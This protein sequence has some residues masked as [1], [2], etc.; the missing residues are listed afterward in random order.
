MPVPMLPL[1]APG[2]VLL[3]NTCYEDGN[4]AMWDTVLKTLGGRREGD[5]VV[6]GD[7]GAGAG[8][9]VALR[10]TASPA[11]DYLHAGDFPALRPPGFTAPIIVQ[12]DIPAVFGGDAPLLVDLREVPGRGVRVPVER[13]ATVV[14]GLHDGTITFAELIRAMDRCGTYL[15]DAGAPTNPTPTDVTRTDYPRLPL[16]PSGT[17][18]VRTDFTNEEGW[19]SLVSALVTLDDDGYLS[20][21]ADPAETSLIARVVNDPAFDALQPGQVPALIPT[22]T[23]NDHHTTMVALADAQ[24]LTTPAHRLLAVDLYDTPGQS[25]RIPLSG[26]AAMAVNLEIANMGFYEYENYED[27]VH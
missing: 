4:S 25:L 5:V 24:T 26:A 21:D 16:C 27:W 18:L 17:L 3:V 22:V 20:P 6:I 2:E 19:T 9:E 12:A 11:W 8:P 15:G 23:R 1:P 14:T 7:D 13:L 10:L